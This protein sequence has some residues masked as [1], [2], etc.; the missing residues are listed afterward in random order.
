MTHISLCTMYSRPDHN[1]TLGYIN[2]S[3]I[4]SAFVGFSAEES[5]IFTAWSVLQLLDVGIV[6]GA[7][8]RYRENRQNQSSDAGA[9]M[10]PT[11]TTRNI[12]SRHTFEGQIVPAHSG[13][14]E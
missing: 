11:W 1:R 5:K 4:Q 7:D 12:R 6:S 8:Q 10:T 9:P 3:L 14:S 2:L 13:H